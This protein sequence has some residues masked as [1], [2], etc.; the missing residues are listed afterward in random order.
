MQITKQDHDLNHKFFGDIYYIIRDYISLT[1][2]YNDFMQFVLKNG[3]SIEYIPDI[4]MH[5]YIL[6]KNIIVSIVE[7]LQ[8]RNNDFAIGS[9]ICLF[10]PQQNLKFLSLIDGMHDGYVYYH[11]GNQFTITYK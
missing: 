1:L 9:V 7:P 4:S 3:E 5:Q 11:S 6:P 8:V 10:P 2:D